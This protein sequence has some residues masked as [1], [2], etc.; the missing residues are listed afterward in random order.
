MTQKNRFVALGLALLFFGGISIGSAVASPASIPSTASGVATIVPA[1]DPLDLSSS[2]VYDPDN[3][4]GNGI[5]QVRSS[6]S[7][8]ANNDMYLYVAIVDTYSG[9]NPTEW[10]TRTMEASSLPENSYLLSVAIS[11][12]QYSASSTIGSDINSA[13]VNELAFQIVQPQLD[14]GDY[15]SA[16]TSFAQQ[17][18][19]MKLSKEANTA[20]PDTGMTQEGINRWFIVVLI[21]AMVIAVVLAITVYRRNTADMDYDEDE[22]DV[23]YSALEDADAAAEVEGEELTLAS[24]AEAAFL[25]QAQPADTGDDIQ[26]LD[27][28][29]PKTY[30]TVQ[31]FVPYE[32]PLET[33]ETS[34]QIPETATESTPESTP[35][36]SD[37]TQPQ[38]EVAPES[39]P[40]FEVAP[41]SEP[42][43]AQVLEPE[44]VPAEQAPA[45]P[46]SPVEQTPP[47]PELSPEELAQAQ[48]NF[49]YAV[50][51]LNKLTTSIFSAAEDLHASNL[52]LGAGETHELSQAL[53]QARTRA[54]ALMNGVAGLEG[55][56]E[57]EAAQVAIE[58][59]QIKTELKTHVTQIAKKRHHPSQTANNIN[60]LITQWNQIR[61]QVQPAQAIYT[62]L[63]ETYPSLDLA[64]ADANLNRGKR[65]LK[66]SYKGLK[67]AQTSLQSGDTKTGI[68]YTRGAERALTQADL[69]IDYLSKLSDFLDR[70]ML[71]LQLLE[72]Q[73]R[74][75]LDAI[76]QND[77]SN[78]P[79]LVI[80]E[81]ALE[82]AREALNGNGDPIEA[83]SQLCSVQTSLYR[84][85]I[86][87]PAVSQ[88]FLGWQSNLPSRLEWIETYF[89][90]VRENL[91]LR[92][93]SA[94]PMLALELTRC[95]QLLERSKQHLDDDYVKTAFTMSTC[96]EMLGQLN[97]EIPAQFPEK[98]PNRQ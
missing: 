64:Q 6:V 31:E 7:A 9:F 54:S 62:R 85:Y 14:S 57:S 68:K 18:L 52:L 79:D 95:E 17:L 73:V 34:E 43:P 2:P 76:R 27:E 19:Q 63:V 59:K 20:S 13:E 30:P 3:I 67:I 35:E 89:E 45:E 55:M 4:L 28:V 92:R 8:I 96:V 82:S 60:H 86:A 26:F 23:D 29:Q 49:E 75:T 50:A 11:D 74:Q 84:S 16:I 51:E 21:L 12:H 1:A 66:A 39:E 70:S 97:S 41:E 24:P 87:D 77:P 48:E 78:T 71:A 56:S 91:L 22:T 42:I 80:A 37:A 53:T 5:Y 10:N 81:R 25:A 38:F 69:A 46:E 65:L 58:A 94:D 90:L 83:N 15:A 47:V 72:T 61:A 93:K 40:Q 88:L 36:E 33:Y 98:N 32:E 44:I